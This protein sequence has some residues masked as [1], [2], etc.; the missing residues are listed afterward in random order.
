[1]LEP[2]QAVPAPPPEGHSPR[3]LV[4]LDPLLDLVTLRGLRTLWLPNWCMP[5]KQMLQWQQL[6]QVRLP[7]CARARPPPCAC[8]HA[9]KERGRR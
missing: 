4:L 3:D 6:L 2:R 9:W 7:A 1:M 5:I 8:A